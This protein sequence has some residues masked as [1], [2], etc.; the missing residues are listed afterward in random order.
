M[1]QVALEILDAAL[2]TVVRGTD[3]EIGQPALAREIPRVQCFIDSLTGDGDLAVLVLGQPQHGVEIDRYDRVD[4]GRVDSVRV[5]SIG[6]RQR[7]ATGGTDLSAGWQCGQHRAAG[8]PW[9][10]QV[11][12]LSS[13]DH[14]WPLA[15]RRTAGKKNQA[16]PHCPGPMPPS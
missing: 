2:V 4:V 7:A 15:G 5:N 10:W 14:G 3:V 13:A 11:I 1:D 16:C 12:R 6:A 9:R 8:F